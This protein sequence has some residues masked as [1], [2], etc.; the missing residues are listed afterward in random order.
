MLVKIKRQ[1]RLAKLLYN[2]IFKEELKSP[3]KVP[4][5]KRLY[6]LSKGFHSHV[7]D[8]YNLKD[9]SLD[10]YFSDWAKAKMSMMYDSRNIRAGYQYGLNNKLFSTALLGQYLRTPKIYAIIEHGLILSLH[11]EAENILATPTWV[12][13]C[14]SAGGKLV[15]KPSAEGRG[16]G[17]FILSSHDGNLYINDVIVTEDEVNS[18][19]KTLNEYL[20]LEFLYQDEYTASLYPNSVN[21]IRIITI[22]EPDSHRPY[23][24]MAVQR[25]GRDSSQPVDNWNRGGLC[26]QIHLETGTLG[27]AAT[28]E[29]K[30]RHIAWYDRHPDTNAPIKGL[31]VPDWNQVKETILDTASHLSYYKYLSWDV[32]KLDEGIAVIEADTIS[33][34]ETLQVHKPMLSDERVKKFLE[35]LGYVKKTER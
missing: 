17:I 10:D 3:T 34:I 9:F 8:L 24:P 23:M 26:A 4:V 18:R 20:I 11:P 29:G 27:S 2:F 14:Y 32:V 31:T 12:D 35:H 21:T 1:Y 15:F 6:L 28:R 19:I 22:I 25:I 5:L 16:R 13:R 7:A 30:D 33:G